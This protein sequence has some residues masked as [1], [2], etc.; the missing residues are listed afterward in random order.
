MS[1]F[2]LDTSE[3]REFW[4]VTPYSIDRVRVLFHNGMD[5]YAV[6]TDIYQDGEKVAA[7]SLAEQDD[8]FKLSDVEGVRQRM[9]EIIGN[10]RAELVRFEEMQGIA[11]EPQIHPDRQAEPAPGLLSPEELRQAE[12][13]PG[14]LSP[15]ELRQTASHFEIA[16]TMPWGSH[17]TKYLSASGEVIGVV[18]KAP[19][20]PEIS[21]PWIKHSCESEPQRRGEK[22]TILR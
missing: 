15:E 21:C 19:G 5:Q 3:G 12:P 4:R 9:R 13:A 1:R 2:N 10:A 11:E 20:E 14:L 16:L 17:W 8:L 6:E 18:F 7:E 22:W